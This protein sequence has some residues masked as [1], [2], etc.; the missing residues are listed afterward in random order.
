MS[1]YTP[2]PHRSRS[3]RNTRKRPSQGT[4]H[5]TAPAAAPLPDNDALLDFEP[6]PH[7]APRKNSITPDRQRKFIAH[8]AATGIVR[9]AALHIGASLEAL[10]RLRAK[11]GG[12]EFAAAWEAAVDRGVA[13][14]EDCALARA[15]E[16]E[17]RMVVSGGQVLGTERRHND[18]LVMFFLRQRRG[19]RYA[20]NAYAA[21]RPGHPV[22]EAIREEVIAEH[23]RG[24]D[25]DAVVDRLNAKLDRIYERQMARKAKAERDAEAAKTDEDRRREAIL[26]ECATLPV[27]KLEAMAAQFGLA[28]AAPAL[29][30]G[31]RVR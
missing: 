13:R 15:I 19:Q 18:A 25:K 10:Y 6:V 24:Y 26:A 23:E 3:A 12:E 2:I 22:Y 21:L 29:P 1:R 7:V 28:C 30:A 16:G 17:E 4:S 31:P 20:A 5:V 8:L 9:Q 11:P 14:L 27:A